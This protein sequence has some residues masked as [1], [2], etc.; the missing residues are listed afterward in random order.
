MRPQ[1]RTAAPPTAKENTPEALVR[2]K[3]K[4][5]QAIQPADPRRVSYNQQDKAG[6]KRITDLFDTLIE[7]RGLTD[8]D[9]PS[10]RSDGSLR[11]RRYK[12]A[13][14]KSSS[15]AALCAR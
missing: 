10:Y 6:G 8:C 12:G 13:G 11:D 4:V 2:P 1:T 5:L 14:G 9:S 7:G 15:A 3:P